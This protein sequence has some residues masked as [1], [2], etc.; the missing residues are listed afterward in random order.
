MFRLRIGS[1]AR[2][3]GEAARKP[4][5]P[6][7]RGDVSPW[8]KRSDS[9]GNR[10]D[11]ARNCTAG[12]GFPFGGRCDL[13]PV[14]RARGG[15]AGTVDPF[16]Q[17]VTDILAYDRH[18]H[19][20]PGRIRTSRGSGPIR[21]PSAL[22]R[23]VLKIIRKDSIHERSGRIGGGKTTPDAVEVPADD[24]CPGDESDPADHRAGPS[25]HHV[26]PVVIPGD[27]FRETGEH[28]ER[29]NHR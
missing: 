11:G 17:G 3:R 12:T 15:L 8:G 7:I 22:R 18:D 13:V 27:L 6:R 4:K 1:I 29:R 2:D 5:G 24:R 21:I 10:M 9:A 14:D 19:S 16:E 28:G 25:R 20:P 26:A 23:D